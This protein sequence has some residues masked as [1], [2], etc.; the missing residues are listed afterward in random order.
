MSLIWF[1]T[2]SGACYRIDQGDHHDLFCPSDA[3]KI[4]S[5][6]ALLNWPSDLAVASFGFDRRRPRFSIV[7]RPTT[8]YLTIANLVAVVGIVSG[9]CAIYLAVMKAVGR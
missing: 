8:N 7:V 6:D 3:Y 2:E 1:W 5:R 4:Q 9:L